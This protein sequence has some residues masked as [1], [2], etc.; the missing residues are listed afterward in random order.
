[1]AR[2]DLAGGLY[3][4]HHRHLEVH[5]HEVGPQR[6]HLAQRLFA[7]M[8][9]ADHLDVRMRA[10]HDTQPLAHDRLVIHEQDANH[11]FSPTGVS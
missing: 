4:V 7:I 10:E 11:R 2:A 9:D 8:R 1:M 6:L 3:A 5:Q